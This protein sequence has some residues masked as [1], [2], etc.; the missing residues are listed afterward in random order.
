MN[1][2]GGQRKSLWLGMGGERVRGKENPWLE[3]LQCAKFDY[4]EMLHEISLHGKSPNEK[5]ADMTGF[6]CDHPL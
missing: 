5:Q 2:K 4:E 6:M 3:N 1:G